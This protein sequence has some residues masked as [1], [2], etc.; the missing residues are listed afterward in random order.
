MNFYPGVIHQHG[1]FPLSYRISPLETPPTFFYVGIPLSNPD[2]T[3][4]TFATFSK[5]SNT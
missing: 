3:D 4:K 5:P 1:T 2:P